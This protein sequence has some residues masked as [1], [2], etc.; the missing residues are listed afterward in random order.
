MAMAEGFEAQEKD[1]WADRTVTSVSSTD[2]SVE[3]SAKEDAR[4]P[5]HYIEVC[6]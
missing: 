5:V 6:E 2:P 1:G 4:S 3:A